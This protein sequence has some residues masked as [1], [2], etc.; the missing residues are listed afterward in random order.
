MAA[1]RNLGALVQLHGRADYRPDTAALA[2]DQLTSARRARGL[3]FAE[4]ADLLTP[5]VSWPVTPQAVES[6][7]S[8]AVPPGD[9]LVAAGLLSHGSGP[10]D[11][12]TTTSDVLGRIIRDRFSDV[13]AVYRTRSEFLAHLPPHDLFDEAKDV[14]TAVLSLNLICQQYADDNLRA[15]LKAGATF[16]CL[17]LDPKGEAIKAREVEEGYPGGHLAALTGLNI[18]TLQ[19]RV[20]T[21]LPA[22]A[23]KRLLVATYD[24]TIR[25]NILIVDSQI[26]VAQPYLPATRGLDSPTFVIQR[27][28]STAGLFPMFSQIFDDLWQAGTRL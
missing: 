16:R 17:F 6:W 1:E 7:E 26:C 3:T 4:F 28:W 5:L 24:R 11:D 2:R 20:K 23:R 19:E 14:R 15:R 27:R 12:Q 21:K 25:F 8:T 10:A 18:Q 13:T 22:A 9:V